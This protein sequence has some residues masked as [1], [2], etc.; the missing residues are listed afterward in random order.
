MSNRLP[1]R[2][3]H[4]EG[5][6]RIRQG[7]GGLVTALAPV[8]RD[9]G[10]LWVGWP[11]A[12]GPGLNAVC[13]QFSK[14]AGYL[15]RPV[16]LDDADVAGFYQG[17]SNEIVWPLFHEFMLP[18]N[19]LPTYWE[20]YRRANAKFSAAVAA[21]GRPDDFIWVHDYHLM[22]MAKQLKE[23][24]KSFRV[25]FFLHIPFPPADIFLR[26]PWRRQV[27]DA[28]LEFDLVGFQTL[29][30]RVNF[31]ESVRRLYPGSRRK[32]RGQVVSVSSRGR[33]T[34]IGGFPISI[35]FQSF[36]RDAARQ[37]AV[38][39]AR[40]LRE[41]FGNRFVLF[42]AD[43]LDYSK[44][45]PERLNAFAHLLESSP[46]L[47]GKVCL[48]QVTV[49]SR[50]EVPM[51]RDM[52]AQVERLVSGIN[53]RFATPGWTPVNYIYRNLPR[54]E[55]I[56]YYMAADMCL[57]TSL[58][59]GMNL[60]AKE[61]VACNAALTGT[62]CLSEFAGAAMEFHRHAAMINPFDVEGVARAIR[63]AMDTPAA[64]R[65]R[66]MRALRD[67]LRRFDVFQWVDSFLMAAFSKRLGD[68]PT[69][70][71]DFYL[72]VQDRMG[73]PWD[74]PWSLDETPTP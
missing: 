23:M 6:L 2:V 17:F 74:E 56:T 7:A 31:A 44:G 61:Y 24:G 28:L 72:T 5:K 4:E 71:G 36:V 47:H 52:L 34:R 68:F 50:E 1:V 42:G 65:R 20:A 15:L 45:I 63:E 18:C 58:G 70:D 12:T 39:A 14:D 3:T 27:V 33:Q 59:D 48:I 8:L 9:R 10:G 53:G 66:H 64:V 46:E 55:L 40:K 13:R 54:E 69:K 51:Y 67:I 37:E 60:V 26:L 43:R 49:P 11:G 32:G 30:D 38:A 25:G 73:P 41:A 35:D 22:L 21:A 57:V 19:F 29:K 62:L 16:E